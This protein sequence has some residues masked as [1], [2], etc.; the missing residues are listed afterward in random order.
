M[1]CAQWVANAGDSRCIISRKGKALA[2]SEDHK[3]A[4]P[5]EFSLAGL[6]VGTLVLVDHFTLHGSGPN[7]AR[8]R[9]RMASLGYAGPHIAT[10]VPGE[11]E[12]TRARNIAVLGA[13]E[14]GELA[15]YYTP[16]GWDV[17]AEQQCD[18]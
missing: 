11:A 2:L 4:L 5:G 1:L 17:R 14:A 16:P 7:V 9:R 13:R 8:A 15:D 3:P 10:H 18:T 12:P 6:P